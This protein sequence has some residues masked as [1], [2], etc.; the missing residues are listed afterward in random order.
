MIIVFLFGLK[1]FPYNIYWIINCYY[2]NTDYMYTEL[3]LVFISQKNLQN[4]N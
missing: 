1:H 2:N 3:Q 4:S